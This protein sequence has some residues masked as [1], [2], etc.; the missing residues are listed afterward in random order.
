M[1]STLANVEIVPDSDVTGAAVVVSVAL[2]A[3]VVDLPK[4]GQ[5]CARIR[6]GDAAGVVPE[7]PRRRSGQ[8]MR[9]F[10]P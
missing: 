2:A 7:A 3:V 8:S 4:S 10:S 6:P 5:P 9:I 1:F